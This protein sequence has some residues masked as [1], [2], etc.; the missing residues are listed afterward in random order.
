M[1]SSQAPSGARTMSGQID[2][3]TPEQLRP[4]SRVAGITALLGAPAPWRLLVVAI[5]IPSVF[6]WLIWWGEH[7]GL[8]SRGLGVVLFA[9]ACA[10]TFLAVIAWA[11]ATLDRAERERRA[12]TEQLRQ[13]TRQETAGAY[14]R[15][16][17]EASLDPLVTIAADGKI[18]DVNSA[19]EKV[20]GFSRHELIGTD[21][22]GYF[23]EPERARAGYQHVFRQGWVQDYELGVRHRDGRVTPVLYNASVYRDEAGQVV[24]VFAAARDISE[25]K[26]AERELRR[27][28]RA[29]RTI[30]E[31]NQVI[32]RAQE[33]QELL[34]G[35][36]GIL[37][38]E[39]GYRM[40][41]VGYAEQ[42]TGKSVRPV[43][44]AGFEDGYLESAQITWA[45]AERGRGPTGRAI[46][47]GEPSIARNTQQDP[48]FAPWRDEARRRGFASSIGLPLILNGRTLGALMLYSQSADAFDEQE[49]RLL[50]E[51]AQDL[52]YGI[53]A[54]RTRAERK[55][56]EAELHQL[57]TTLLHLRDEERQRIARELHDSAGQ[58][59][60]ALS[61]NL[62]W[63]DQQA[64]SSGPRVREVL[65]ESA[66]I[67]K[68]CAQEIRDFSY[69]LHPPMLEE[70]GLASALRWYAEGFGRRS[71]IQVTLE[72]PED[73]RRLSHDEEIA[74]FRVVQ[75]CLTN[76][77]RHSGSP[78]VRI[79]IVEDA[80]T[81]SLEIADEGHG[82]Q[83]AAPEPADGGR[84]MGV[85]VL[86]M[87]ERMRDLGGHL[88][89]RSDGHGTTIRAS[90]P[91]LEKAA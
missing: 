21:F 28:N 25:R 66:E 90:L 74:L 68:R 18:T 48:D 20:T 64:E 42:D 1:E 80:K 2:P 19:T 5:V 85:G 70:Y 39:G 7:S 77:H 61:M 76:V 33:E 17:I 14:N 31:C 41:W 40:A 59:L 9:I 81:L 27:L 45:D 60:A 23:T 58:N 54:L 29:L 11:A 34:Y 55:R 71:G 12:A 35:V 56:A 44:S 10:A 37:L 6:G 24:G 78:T 38:K 67:V 32:V 82:L 84:R 15:S 43:A 73:L 8:F 30:S 36:C 91:L 86:G 22:S 50:T 89:I 46:R 79:R 4:A 53:R 72:V 83:A 63:I 87:Q 57:S 69:L 88:E 75:E 26:K 62:A 3:R 52:A 65:A 47:T 51:L 16:L 13:R 49:V